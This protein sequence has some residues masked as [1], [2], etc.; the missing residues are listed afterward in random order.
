MTLLEVIKDASINSKSL[1]SPL[2]YPIVLN[3]DSILPTLKA[4]VKD[5]S[6]SS[7]VRPLIGWHI[8]P[9]DAEIVDIN[10]KFF[11]ELNAKVK[12]TN[13]FDKG[14][15]ISS[16]NS[17]LENIRDKAG[18]VIEVDS[19]RSEYNKTLIDK[20]GV[21]MGKDVASLVLNGCV[22]LEMW[23]VVEALIVNAIIDHSCYSNLITK[24]VEKKRS[25]LICLCIKHAFDLGSSEILT[26]LRYFLS[27]SKDAYNSMLSVKIEWERQA[28]L[29]IQILNDSKPKRKK[30]L[31]AKEASILLMMAYDGFSASETCLHYLIAS[32][33]INDVMLSP[34]LSK[35][36]GKELLNLIRYLGKWLKKYERFPQAGP[37]PRASSVLRL[38]A[39]DWVPKLE[40]V[41]KC[42]GLL[43]DEKFSSLVLHPLFHEELRS[44]EG[45][46][47][48]LTAEAKFCHLT[49]DVVGKLTIEAKNL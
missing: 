9:K 40:D 33:N 4:E 8:A 32:S 27:P 28:V 31:L 38:E 34:S 1:D 44:I 14:E 10:K 3:P 25:D 23:E 6:T 16:L 20:L 39:C 7:L 5:E 37:C 43:L 17:Y 21:Y 22:S 19:S 15:F 41:I 18:V 35:L 11:T 48:C 29:A 24:L 2:D 13:N 26:I 36:N 45:V 47:S 30:L 12:N 42:L 49:A 46:V